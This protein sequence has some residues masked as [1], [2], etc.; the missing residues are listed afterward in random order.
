MKHTSNAVLLI[1]K[2]INWLLWGF[3]TRQTILFPRF[4]PSGLI[5]YKVNENDQFN[6]LI[7]VEFGGKQFVTFQSS[8]IPRHFRFRS[9]C[10]RPPCRNALYLVYLSTCKMFIFKHTSR[11]RL[12]VILGNRN[13]LFSCLLLSWLQE[14]ISFTNKNKKQCD[15]NLYSKNK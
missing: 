9:L 6:K 11:H 10:F 7:G 12:C 5:S 15:L 3:K 13:I 8:T 4:P 2:A 1:N 14:M